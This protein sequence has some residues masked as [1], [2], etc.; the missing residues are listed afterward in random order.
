MLQNSDA[1]NWGASLYLQIESTHIETREFTSFNAVTHLSDR[2]PSDEVQVD[3]LQFITFTFA[4]HDAHL[5]TQ[6]NVPLVLGRS[7]PN[8]RRF[9]GIDLTPYNAYDLGVSRFHAFINQYNNQAVIVDNES[10]NG[11]FINGEQLRPLR[12][13][14]LLTGD[15]LELG[16]LRLSITIE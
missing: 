4:D 14:V 13:Y 7:Y 15:L 10:V 2:V 11:T 3:S 1:K 16:G 5:T 8:N 9:D 12:P 6:L